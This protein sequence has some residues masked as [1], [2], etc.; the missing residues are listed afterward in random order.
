MQISITPVDKKAAEKGKWTKY[1][2]V[3]LC[4]ARSNN[5]RFRACFRKL[6]A[7]YQIEMEEGKLNEELSAEIMAEALGQEVLVDWNNFNI[8]AE[9]LVYSA[10]NAKSLLLNDPDCQEFVVEFSEKLSNYLKE[11][12]EQV[13]GES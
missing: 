6:I 13:A 12:Q 9:P 7:P 8:N 2:G 3:D 10:E 1:R 11:T 5:T 4:I